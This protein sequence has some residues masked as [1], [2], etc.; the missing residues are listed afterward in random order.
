MIEQHP[1]LAIM[2]LGSS[3]LVG[4]VKMA[5]KP[6]KMTILSALSLMD[7]VTSQEMAEVLDE[8]LLENISSVLHCDHSD[9]FDVVP[10]KDGLTNMSCSFRVGDKRYVY[11]HPGVGTEELVDRQAEMEAQHIAKELGLDNTFIYEDPKLGWKISHFVENSSTINPHDPEQLK[12]A[13]ILARTLHDCGKTVDRQ[14]DFYDEGARYMS[15]TECCG[16]IEVPRFYAMAEK[17]KR[18]SEFVRG[19]NSPLCLTHNDFFELNI[20]RDTDDRYYLIDWEYAG[21]GDYANDLATFAVCCKLSYEEI[22]QALEYYFD[23]KPTP[24][25]LR[26][27]LALVGLAGWC[28]TVWSV[29]KECQGAY[30]GNWIYTYMKYAKEYV[31][32]GLK[33]YEEAQ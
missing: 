22:E 28:W 10:M 4:V 17:A 32:L 14:F 2:R 23:R 33:L 24:E 12:Q 6:S 11:R 25:E 19:D 31:N 8:R 21:M 29:Y 3:Q 9:V 7:G 30:V 27:N 20:L 13:M 18:L 1:C 16:E 26:H 15:L 5:R